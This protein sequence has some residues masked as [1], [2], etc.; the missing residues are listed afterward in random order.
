MPQQH[1]VKQGECLTEIA[2]KYGFASWQSLWDAPGN[3]K[4]REKRR[5]PNVL[6]PGD[7]IEI[8]DR[9]TKLEPIASGM[10]HRFQRHM[11]MKL[12]RLQLKDPTNESRFS[13]R[14]YTLKL[15]KPGGAMG[16]VV[17]VEGD[18]DDTG[19]LE[20]EIP[21]NTHEGTLVIE[22]EDSIFNLPLLIDHL[23]PVDENTGI[24]VRLNNLGFHC[25]KVDGHIGPRTREVLRLFQ[26]SKSFDTTGVADANT[27]EALRTD[28]GS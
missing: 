28:H 22:F 24:Q 27:R 26:A 1:R 20:K 5:E 10:K 17:E 15:Q 25:G 18:L 6:F 11:P 8:P 12:L 19:K 14:S 21:I 9:H 2:S 4:L 16:D 23:D 13:N 7:L 3:K